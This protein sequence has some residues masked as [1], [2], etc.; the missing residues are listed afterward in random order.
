[1]AAKRAAFVVIASGATAVSSVPT[2]STSSDIIPWKGDMTASTGS[3]CAKDHYT[4]RY[5]GSE[6][7][8]SVQYII[9]FDS[10]TRN[11]K[12]VISYH[13]KGSS[14]GGASAVR[15]KTSFHPGIEIIGPTYLPYSTCTF[16]RRM[17]ELP[18]LY[19]APYS[20]LT[21]CLPILLPLDPRIDE[22]FR[23][24]SADYVN[25]RF[26]RGHMV[27]AADMAISQ[28]AMQVDKFTS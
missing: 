15:A 2:T 25:S 26:D 8:S 3:F 10:K 20:R 11:P 1:M 12:Y 22:C 27:P 13:P 24:K 16:H 14:A 7:S 9:H 5:K 4:L 6:S 19:S 23:V 18:Q 28:E 17:I 21:D